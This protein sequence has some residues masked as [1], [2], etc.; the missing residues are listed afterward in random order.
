M[1][2]VGKNIVTTNLLPF[3]KI[4]INTE[5]WALRL[6][7]NKGF[8]IT[9][10]NTTSCFASGVVSQ[11]IRWGKG[12]QLFIFKLYDRIV[13][14]INNNMYPLHRTCI[15]ILH[16]AI[17]LS[18]AKYYGLAKSVTRSISLA[19]VASTPKDLIAMFTFQFC[20]DG[21]S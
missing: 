17:T 6:I 9:S 18:S 14:H 21:G 3:Y 10:V 13:L 8:Y 5:T 11:I 19:V 7:N 4:A 1:E 15:T 16:R 12:N 20:K 2:G